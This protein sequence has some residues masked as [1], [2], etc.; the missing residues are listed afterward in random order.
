MADVFGEGPDGTPAARLRALSYENLDPTDFEEL[1]CDLMSELGFVNVDW[2]KGTP[3]RSSPSDRGRDIVAQ[4][5]IEDVDGHRRFET[6]FVDAK[7]YAK[8]VP[9]EALQGLFAWAET[10]RPDV[11]LVVASGFLSNAAKDWIASYRQNR[12]PAFRIKHWERPDLAKMIDA[13]RDLL[14]KH[15]IMEV[16]S[17][18]TRSSPVTWCSDR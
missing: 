4:R 14:W 1:V 10:E 7:H 17:V 15:D 5:M 12:A 2:R 11:A 13:H 3:K 18:R 9:P 6:W 8:G 16:D